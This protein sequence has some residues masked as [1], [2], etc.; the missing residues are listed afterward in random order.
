M[1]SSVEERGQ[2]DDCRGSQGKGTYHFEDFILLEV[3][4]GE[5]E[6]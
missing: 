5:D 2:R 3:S 6:A 1:G 4:E